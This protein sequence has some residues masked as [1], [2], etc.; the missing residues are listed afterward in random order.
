LSN[1]NVAI[2]GRS[3]FARLALAAGLAGFA[4]FLPQ[5]GQAE[6][7]SPWA[8]FLGN[9]RGSGE[10]I[11][12]DGTRERISCRGKYS[13]SS[14][15]EALSLSVRCASDS[16]SFDIG[17]YL[18]ANGQSVSGDFQEYSRKVE[19]HVTGRL[20]DGVL[21]GT[22]AGASFTAETSLR[23]SGRKQTFSLRTRGAQTVRAEVT[24]TREG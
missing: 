16:F 15:G 22:I 4:S 23:V 9:W 6:S 2:S 14:G 1:F 12:A 20:G 18:V 21:E 11:E 24:L 3:L 8:K 10:V 7:A 13:I 5:L 17:S 19:G